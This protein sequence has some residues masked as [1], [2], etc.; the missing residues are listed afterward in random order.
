MSSDI[1]KEVWAAEKKIRDHIR[2]TPADFSPF[3]SG[4]ANCRVF[5]KLEICQITG[6]FKFRGVV[7]KF[8]S[9]SDTRIKRGLVTASSGNHAAAFAHMVA[10]SGT[11]GTIYLP[12]NASAA[13]IETLRLD[14]VEL[15]FHGRDCVQTETFARREAVASGR[16]FVSPYNDP[17]IIAGQGTIAVELLEQVGTIDAVLVPVGGG[18]LIS[19][20]AG[21]LK[22]VDENVEIIG[23]QPQN[24]PVMQASVR[25]GRILPMESKPT[26]AD[27]TAGGIEDGSITF[28]ICRRLVDDFILVSEE[29]IRSALRLMIAKHQIVLEGA[30]A[31]PVAAF[32]KSRGRFTNRNVVLILS[33]KKISY[34]QLKSVVI[35]DGTGNE[36]PPIAK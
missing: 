36:A 28:D 1:K 19:G 31:L 34:R 26:L 21:Y 23:C 14:G 4:L 30:A 9:L 17:Q 24:S 29:E 22:S 16:V 13:K 10:T 15:K 35:E 18:G 20:I 2:R 6:S 8:L 7:S 5:L 25:A 12:E 27:G 11:K 32:L 33:G 3:L